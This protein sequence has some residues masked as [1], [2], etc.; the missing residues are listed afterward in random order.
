MQDDEA[1]I[2]RDSVARVMSN[3]ESTSEI[4]EENDEKTGVIDDT[5]LSESNGDEDQ[6]HGDSD[7]PRRSSRIRKKPDYLN[8]YICLTEVE[9]ERL[10]LMIIEEP[11]DYNE[12]KN[13]REWVFACEDEIDSIT[14]NKCWDTVDPPIGCKPI[15]L[16]WVFKVK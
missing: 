9:G 12:A 16:K 13:S 7:Q 8:D 3:A 4:E 10:L 6:D 14:K 1:T 11:W 15:G 2:E 5:A